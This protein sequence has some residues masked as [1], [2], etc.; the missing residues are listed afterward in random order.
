MFW[1]LSRFWKWVQNACLK[2]FFASFYDLTSD[3]IF[4]VI[5]PCNNIIE[6]YKEKSFQKW[7]LILYHIFGSG[8]KMHLKNNFC[9]FWPN[10]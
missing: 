10:F 5:C 8:Q 7:F 1:I 6:N 9:C 3:A 4:S 2:T